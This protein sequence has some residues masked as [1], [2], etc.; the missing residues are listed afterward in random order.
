MAERLLDGTVALV[1]GASSGTGWHYVWDEEQVRLLYACS[2]LTAQ[3]A[4]ECHIAPR[5]MRPYDD[6]VPF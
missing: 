5:D 2:E 3:L 6:D 4:W 1:T